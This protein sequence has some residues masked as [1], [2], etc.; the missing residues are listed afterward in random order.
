MNI[1]LENQVYDF[2][3][4]Q[5]AQRTK[6]AATDINPN[7][8][9]SDLGLQSIDAVLISGEV[10]DH[11]GIEMDPAAIFEHKTLEGFVQFVL[12]LMKI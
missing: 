12:Q 8:V 1:S 2:V 5:V 7:A 10:E 11:F 4:D 6:T 3:R 9:L